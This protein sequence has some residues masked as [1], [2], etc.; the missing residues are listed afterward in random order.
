MTQVAS[1]CVDASNTSGGAFYSSTNELSD[2]RHAV[3][4]IFLTVLLD[5][6]ISLRICLFIVTLVRTGS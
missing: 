4:S 5:L 2:I 1:M 3:D 6:L